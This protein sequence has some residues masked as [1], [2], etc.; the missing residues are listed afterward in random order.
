MK[1]RFISPNVEDLVGYLPRQFYEDQNFW[2]NRIH[3]ED[4]ERIRQSM[5][6]SEDS[7]HHIREYRFLRSDGV[8]V[9][10]RE[11]EILMRNSEGEPLE[12]IGYWAD[13]TERIT[14]EEEKKSLEAQLRQSQK[15]EAVGT[16]AG[17]LAHNFNN[18]LQAISGYVQLLLMDKKEKD[19]DWEY[20][21]R[22]DSA[23]HRASELIGQILT[24]SRKSET[25]LIPV[26]LNRE[27]IQTIMLLEKIIPGMVE[28]KTE[29][30]P[31]LDFHQRRTG[32]TGAG[33]HEPGNQR[34]DAMPQGGR[35]LIETE[36]A[37]LDKDFCKSRLGIEPGP[38]AL[39][40]VSDTGPGI[41]KE[42]IQHIFEPFF[43]TKE[44][45]EGTGLGLSHGL[46]DH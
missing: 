1:L 24:V 4:R 39:M 40:K 18:I 6:L 22:I 36:N 20:L 41:E 31:D 2:I 45:G 27:V 3:P 21:Q 9:W 15:M 5:V 8:Y 11:E 28:I 33:R 12:I 34:R 23:G 17:G 30:D 46:R 43:T 13:K 10:M 26:D 42:N 16:L 25:R 32:S 7:D 35:F 14:A 29:L 37:V 44:K 19:P 38:Y